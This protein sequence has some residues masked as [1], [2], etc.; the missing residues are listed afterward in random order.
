MAKIGI[1]YKATFPNGKCYIGQT[2]KNLNI[3]MNG[4]LNDKA[5]KNPAFCNAMNKYGKD[6][7]EWEIIDEAFSLE[8]LNEKEKYWISF[9]N[10]Y[11]NAI[12]SNGYNMTLGGNSTLGW[13]PSEETKK[14]ISSSLTGL[15]S[16][17]K[18]PQYGKRGELSYWWGR[19]HTEESKN[20]IRLANTGVPKSEES[21][22]KNSVAHI[23]Q[24][25]W[26][27]GIPRT[28]EDRIKISLSLTGRRLSKEALEKQRTCHK[29]E[30][31]GKATLKDKD[32]IIIINRLLKG[33]AIKI[34]AT[35]YSV[36]YNTISLIKSNFTWKHILPE[37]RP[38][39]KEKKLNGN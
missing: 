23:G 17:N 10:S 21:K 32:V 3:R 37:I 18:N 15:F 22:I 12:N 7:I 39:L 9:F 30:K 11:I 14:K 25:A 28:E 19:K 34:L 16:G 1:I 38:L 33:E 24:I 36:S 6:S 2:T 31:H 26:N 20:K 4:H 27:K 8:E 29:G 5:R 13:I 35:E